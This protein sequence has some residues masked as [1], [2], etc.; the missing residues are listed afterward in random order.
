MLGVPE[1]PSGPNDAVQ[2]EESKAQDAGSPSKAAAVAEGML[3]KDATSPAALVDDSPEDVP[4]PDEENLDDLD[5][6]S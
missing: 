5:G 2:M 3:A 4:D 1:K 6:G